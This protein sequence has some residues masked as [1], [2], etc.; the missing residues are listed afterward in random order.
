[1]PCQRVCLLV[2]FFCLVCFYLNAQQF[3]NGSFEINTVGDCGINLPNRTFT[4]SVAN[5]AAIGSKNETDLLSEVCGYGN[6]QDGDYFV[7]IYYLGGSDVVALELSEA[8]KIGESYTLLFYDKAGNTTASKGI[9]EIGVADEPNSFGERLAYVEDITEEWQLRQIQ[10][11]AEIPGKYIV[12][13]IERPSDAWI[14]LDHFSIACPTTIDLGNDSTYCKVE[15]LQLGLYD[16]YQTYLWSDGSTNPTLT[17]DAPGLYWIEVSK[18]GCV[19]KDSIFIEEVV[20]NCDCKIFAPN[21]FSPNND[22]YNDEFLVQTPCNLAEYQLAI[23]NRWGELLFETNDPQIGW[24]GKTGTRRNEAGVY[25]YQLYY[26]FDYQDKGE[27][28]SGDIALIR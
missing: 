4:E 22:G 27:I 19:L 26:R 10:F 7:A 1:M 20:N 17:V 15:N 14:F 6:A 13:R 9:L 12:V 5:V 28:K 23:F 18:D 21:I 3:L 16:T 24:N 8:L 11:T 25:L 2:S